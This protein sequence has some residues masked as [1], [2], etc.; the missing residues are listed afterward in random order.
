MG[1]GAGKADLA[2]G[3]AITPATV[4]DIASN[5][6]QFTADAILLLAGRH[7]LAL[8]DPL[9]AHLDRPPAWTR[10]VTPADLMHHTS[11]IPDYEELL[12]AKG[13]ELTDPAGQQDAVKAILATRPADPSG[14]RFSYSHSNYVLRA[15]AVERVSGKP[16]AT[17]VQQE[18]FDPLRRRMAL[19]PAADVPGKA[20]SYEE[21]DGSFTPPGPPPGRSTET[22]SRRER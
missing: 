2:A 16:F 15:H 8:D 11:G 10:N 12:H 6:R 20:R 14:R 7:R 21:K 19:A 17:F 22:G 5:S 4:F 13:V 1:G 9:S 18:F 3:R